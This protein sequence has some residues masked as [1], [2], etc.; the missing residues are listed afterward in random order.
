MKSKRLTDAE[1]AA[2]HHAAQK[3][4]WRKLAINQYAGEGAHSDVGSEQWAEIVHR[5]ATLPHYDD[6]TETG[7]K[8]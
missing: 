7:N 1:L 5:F 3:D 8:R 2:E 4:C 6:P